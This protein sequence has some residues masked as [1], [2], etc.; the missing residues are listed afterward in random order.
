MTGRNRTIT[1][2]TRVCTSVPTE[3][4]RRLIHLS[5]DTGT[6]KNELVREGVLLLLRYHGR[7]HGLPL[8]ADPTSRATHVTRRTPDRAG[9]ATNNEA[10]RTN[11]RTD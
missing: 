4:A 3:W 2:L 7:A 11:E 9:S 6:P 8:P 5:V 1:S 10:R